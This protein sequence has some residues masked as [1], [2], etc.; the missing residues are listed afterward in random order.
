MP[1]ILIAD[2]DGHIREV[3]RYALEKEGLRVVEAADGREALERAQ[4]GGVDL[5]VLDIRMPEMDGIEVCRT[6]RAQGRL[7]IVFLTS[8]SEEIDRVLGLELGADDY[9]VKPFSPRELVARV[10][11]VLRRAW[12]APQESASPEH[13]VWRALRLDR[14]R[15]ECR[16]DGREVL[17]TATEFALLAALLRRPGKVFTRDELIDRAW[18][19]GI[20]ITDRT[21]DSHVRRIRKK[22]T[23]AGAPEIVET[24]Y[25]VGYRLKDDEE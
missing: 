18:G 25:G 6:L 7:P 10:K 12:P 23:D 13:L 17:F 8:R 9:V 19:P 3:V 11:A 24:V 1:T 22:L 15:H 16:W 14:E 2:D 21:I 20:A 4:R 5:A